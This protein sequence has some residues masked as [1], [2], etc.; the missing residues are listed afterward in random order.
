MNMI[1]KLVYVAA[2]LCAFALSARANVMYVKADATGS[3]DGSS[4]ANAY[5]DFNAALA[6][7]PL[8]RRRC[9]VLAR[10]APTSRL[11][12]HTQ[13]NSTKERSTP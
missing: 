3:G 1:K 12:F 5:T 13:I 8:Y 9:E 2:M 11:I 10:L 4:W 6:A 7:V